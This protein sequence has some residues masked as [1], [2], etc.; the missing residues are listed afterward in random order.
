MTKY[1]IHGRIRAD[2]PVSEIV[3]A[4]DEETACE[5]AQ[6]IVYAK[7]GVHAGGIIDDEIYADRI[8]DERT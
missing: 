6:E 7:C 1:L 8:E 5:I 2:I 3:E 4:E